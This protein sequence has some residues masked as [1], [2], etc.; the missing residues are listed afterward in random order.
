MKGK[1]FEKLGD[2]EN[3]WKLNL[4]LPRMDFKGENPAN[5]QILRSF[6]PII[7]WAISPCASLPSSS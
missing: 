4:E 5:K 1:K 2:H 7:K 6:Y 3:I